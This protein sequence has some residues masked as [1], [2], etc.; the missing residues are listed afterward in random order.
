MFYHKTIHHILLVLC[1]ITA[2]GFVGNY[3]YPG[4]PYNHPNHK[5]VY[6]SHCQGVV[7][8]NH[9]SCIDPDY[10]D[11]RS[12]RPDSFNKC[13]PD[14]ISNCHEFNPFVTCTPGSC[15]KKA[16]GIWTPDPLATSCTYE[17]H[18]CPIVR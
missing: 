12:T 15:G 13:L 11:C 17:L 4:P 3:V 16:G 18:V 10:P 2:G 5:C 14:P 7:M 1:L 8:L 9:G 6:G